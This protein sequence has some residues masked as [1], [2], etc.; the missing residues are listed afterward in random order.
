M[1]NLTEDLKTAAMDRI[2]GQVTG[3]FIL[4]LIFVNWQIP[5]LLFAENGDA[6]HKIETIQALFPCF[7]VWLLNCVALPAILTALYVY[8]VPKLRHWNAM[9]QQGYATDLA[10]KQAKDARE[11]QEEDNLGTKLAVEIHYSLRELDQAIKIIENNNQFMKDLREIGK[12]KGVSESLLT[13]IQKQLDQGHTTLTKLR[14]RL[15]PVN[16]RSSERYLTKIKAPVIR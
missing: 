4:F 15:L 14:E 9:Y 2:N 12:A 10:L 13:E 11:I 16:E 1:A 8:F 6:Q 3:T 7:W 5:V